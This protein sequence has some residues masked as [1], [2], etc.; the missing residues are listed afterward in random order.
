MCKFKWASTHRL[1]YDFFL[2]SSRLQCINHTF[3][4]NAMKI[5]W[6]LQERS[7]PC[8][9][10]GW[11]LCSLLQSF[12]LSD[13]SPLWNY[14]QQERH[15]QLDSVQVP[16]TVWNAFRHPTW[17]PASTPEWQRSYAVGALSCLWALWG[18]IRH[19][20]RAPEMTAGDRIDL[21]SLQCHVQH[22]SL[23]S[24]SKECC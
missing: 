2:T 4:D 5:I 3:L 24:G 21:Q 16:C 8:R 23:V 22:T 13:N 11:A 17:S 20:I 6:G 7:V 19:H 10:F 15:Q 9:L 18:H 12:L 14:F 1:G